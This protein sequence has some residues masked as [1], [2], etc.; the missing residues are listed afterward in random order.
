MKNKGLLW[1]KIFVFG[2]FSSFVLQGCTPDL[3]EDILAWEAETSLGTL[4]Q[5][6]ILEVSPKVGLIDGE[7]RT[8][9]VTVKY[10]LG[11]LP[12]G[13]LMIGFN[14]YSPTMF[15]MVNEARTPIS[16]GSGEHTWEVEANVADWGRAGSFTV[17]VNISEDPIPPSWRPLANDTYVLIP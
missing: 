11:S 8:F 13:N 12:T 4:D 3:A 1:I 7:T 14:S 10:S 2:F 17:Y 9:S 16:N 15:R 5:I 6:E